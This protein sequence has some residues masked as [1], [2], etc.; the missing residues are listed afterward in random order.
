VWNSTDLDSSAAPMDI[1]RTAQRVD[2]GP[3]AHG[4]VKGENQNLLNRNSCV[5]FS[6]TPTLYNSTDSVTPS[7]IEEVT[8]LANL[9]GALTASDHTPEPRR[10]VSILNVFAAVCVSNPAEEVV[11][12]SVQPDF[13]QNI[14]RLVVASNKGLPP[15]SV[16][17]IHD[18]C[19]ALKMMSIKHTLMRPKIS[20]PKFYSTV[21]WPVTYTAE[22]QHLETVIYQFG[23][24]RLQAAFRR[25]FQRTAPLM[26]FWKW[27]QRIA[28]AGRVREG[29]W[30]FMSQLMA[31]CFLI[32]SNLEAGIHEGLA[33]LLH[34]VHTRVENILEVPGLC[35]TWARHT[36]GL[37]NA[38]CK[39]LFLAVS[40][41]PPDIN[42]CGSVLVVT[43]G[44][45]EPDR[46]D[47]S[48]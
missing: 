31:A 28:A 7:A 19:N 47:G 24:K 16:R 29:V 6:W 34:D 45:H 40:N 41:I 1:G 23:H 18:V 30:P 44:P 37:K 14:V 11:A 43:R 33:D 36:P 15:A 35:E 21:R 8:L 20:D 26:K 10:M 3:S 13:K 27:F 25:H 42:F 12:M 22:F 4:D 5:S 48:H 46:V 9:M 38:K 39:F 32:H 2:G 17:H